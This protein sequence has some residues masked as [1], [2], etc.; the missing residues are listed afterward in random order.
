MEGCEIMRAI[1]KVNS[2]SLIVWQSKGRGLRLEG[3]YLKGP[4][5]E[6]FTECEGC[7]G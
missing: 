5:G 4:E 2:L 1:N 6:V 7:M 3:N